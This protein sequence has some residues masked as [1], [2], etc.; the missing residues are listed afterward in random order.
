[1]RA[2]AP[3][4]V[5]ADGR[6]LWLRLGDG[7]GRGRCVRGEIGQPNLRSRVGDRTTTLDVGQDA[8]NEVAHLCQRRDANLKEPGG[9]KR[10]VTET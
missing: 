7:W 3:G 4:L 2:V 8:R 6:L 10:R 1:M 9:E 5:R